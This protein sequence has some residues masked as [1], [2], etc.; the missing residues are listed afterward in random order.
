MMKA[1]QR[2]TVGAT[3]ESVLCNS[4]LMLTVVLLPLISF[5]T[6]SVARNLGMRG[7]RIVRRGQHDDRA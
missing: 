4:L 5:G 2:K 6:R 7:V 1:S 3:G